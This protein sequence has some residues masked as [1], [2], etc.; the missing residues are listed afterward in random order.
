MRFWV[1]HV[2]LYLSIYLSIAKKIN[3]KTLRCKDFIPANMLF[4]IL[5]RLYKGFL[6][7]NK[8]F[9][10]LLVTFVSIFLLFSL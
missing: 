8:D 10:K 7:Q 6:H 9:K 2:S 3:K 4:Y 1:S 5:S